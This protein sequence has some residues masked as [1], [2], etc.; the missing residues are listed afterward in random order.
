MHPLLIEGLSD[1]VGFMGGALV[2]YGL[3][4]LLGLDIFEAGYGLGQLGAI[5][6]VGG[7][8]GG[9]LHLAR[10]WRAARSKSEGAPE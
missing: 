9:G 4:I 8:G 2:G 5:A 7:G 6:L 1:A 10:R 3:G